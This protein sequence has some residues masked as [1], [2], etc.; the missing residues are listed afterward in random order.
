[1]SERQRPSPHGAALGEAMASMIDKIAERAPHLD[2][3]CSSCAFKRGTIPNK[4]AG[5]LKDAFD[6]VVGIDD[7]LFMCHDKPGVVSGRVEPTT[8]CAGYTLAQYATRDEML[9]MIERATAALDAL[10]DEPRSTP[11][12]SLE[13]SS[14]P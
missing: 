14:K 7:A 2:T 6:C 5:T 3:R 9:E 11:V 4:M 13:D 1:M 10:P 8:I 12:A